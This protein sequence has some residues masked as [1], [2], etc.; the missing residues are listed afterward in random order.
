MAL[1]GGFLHILKTEIETALV[2]ARVEKLHMPSRDELVFSFGSARTKKKLFLS[3][4][5]SS[6][7]ICLTEEDIENPLSPPMLCMLFRKHLGNARLIGLSQ[8]GLDRILT[9]TFEGV[10]ELMDP[11]RYH[12]ICELMGRHSNAILTDE[13]YRIIDSVHRITPDISSVRQ[14]LP[15]MLYTPPPAQAKKN[16]LETTNEELA[17]LAFT[18]GEAILSK[19]L[20]NVLEGISPV[21]CREAEVYSCRRSDVPVALLTE[22]E[23]QR[24]L[25]FLGLIR[26]ALSEKPYPVLLAKP[27]KTP[28]EMSFMDI[29]QYG[30]SAL[31]TPFDSPS[32]LVWAYFG[33]KD[34][35]ERIK[36]RS[37][38]LFKVLLSLTERIRRRLVLQKEELL[39]CKEREQYKILG[40]LVTAN[41]YQIQKGDSS[42]L[43]QN[44]YSDGNE[45]ITVPLDPKLSGSANAQS[46]YAKY[47]KLSIAEGILT[48]QIRR[49][50]NELLY[51]DSVME[52]LLYADTRD[53]ID[54]IRSEL[55]SAGYLKGSR[56][57]KKAF[58]KQ[59]IPKPS[60]MVSSDGFEILF[61][62]NNLQNEQIT[63]KEAR[64][65][66]IWLHAKGVSGSHVIIRNG[67]K[68]ISNTALLEAAKIA[69]LYSKNKNMPKV[70][71]DYCPIKYVKKISGAP[72]GL[73]IYDRYKT[74]LTE[75]QDSNS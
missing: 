54:E 66:D 31:K 48:E 71:V 23:K 52:F 12:L 68:V 39:D 22:H 43:L 9:L 75:P 44:F 38:D 56:I 51:L 1:D 62:K 70:E 45:E 4:S 7:K 67:G 65:E 46:Y 59:K 3:A 37:Y 28:F 19:A 26:Q 29:H 30:P 61:G 16:L 57:L 64:S 50:E 69:A 27:D 41:L 10:N 40:D 13:Q 74:I 55:M 11:C 18:Q 8:Q 14:I 47:K 20:L 17:G 60:R 15:G 6:A 25:F 72:P 24:L 32:T 2:G 73:V 35:I 33:E 53:A 34:R 5:P 49:G 21:I 58:K 36:Q 42:V 63:F